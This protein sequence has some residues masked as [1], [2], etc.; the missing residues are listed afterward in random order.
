MVTAMEKPANHS[1]DVALGRMALVEVAAV[2]TSTSNPARAAAVIP[3]AGH[4][5]ELANGAHHCAWILLLHRL[6]SRGHQR[7]D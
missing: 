6:P 7:L 5:I 2:K 1:G 4:V 3:S